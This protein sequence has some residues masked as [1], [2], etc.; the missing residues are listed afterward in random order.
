[1]TCAHVSNTNHAAGSRAYQKSQPA[2][3]TVSQ[4]ESLSQPQDTYLVRPRE[5]QTRHGSLE[6]DT[7]GDE[8]CLPYTPG[9]GRDQEHSDVRV[10]MKLVDQW[11]S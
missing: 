6:R 4:T 3:L 1:M 10:S 11:H 5:V 2:Y 8:Q 7:G 9:H